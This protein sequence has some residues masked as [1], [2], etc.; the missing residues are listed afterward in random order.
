[1]NKTLK[2]DNNDL[3]DKNNHLIHLVKE[4]EITVQ[5][6]TDRIKDLDVF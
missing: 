6:L 3:L 2:R 4:K 5:E 1:M